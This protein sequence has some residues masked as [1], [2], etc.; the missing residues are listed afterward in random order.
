MVTILQSYQKKS[1][2]FT[3][4]EKVKLFIFLNIKTNPSWFDLKEFDKFLN[5]DSNHDFYKVL[6]MV[7]KGII[8]RGW[9]IQITILPTNVAMCQIMKHGYDTIS[10]TRESEAEA[11][12][13]ACTRMCE[14]IGI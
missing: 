9:T 8:K 14:I 7:K 4:A 6:Q 3:D 11:L 13:K 12:L 2:K 10:E 1:M 5:P